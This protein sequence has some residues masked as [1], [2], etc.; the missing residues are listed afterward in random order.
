MLWEDPV[1]RYMTSSSFSPSCEKRWKM[2][3]REGNVSKWSVLVSFF[4]VG[5]C[6]FTWNLLSETGY[7]GQSSF[8][9]KPVKHYLWV[10]TYLW[11][12]LFFSTSLLEFV[13][14]RSTKLVP[15][16]VERRRSGSPPLCLFMIRVD[17][18]IKTRRMKAPKLPVSNCFPQWWFFFPLP[19]MMLPFKGCL[20]CKLFPQF[21]SL[22]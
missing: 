5:D 20:I 1:G 6:K 9:V 11:P 19:K 13:C 22:Q 12:A 10:A 3:W 18:A 21:I 14:S 2:V 17:G 4:Q 8:V 7:H 15:P 16:P